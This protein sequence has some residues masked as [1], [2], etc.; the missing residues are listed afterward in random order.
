ML[1]RG[2]LFQARSQ[3]DPALPFRKVKER[4][5]KADVL[6][7]NL[8]SM[9]SDKGSDQGSQYSF[10]APPKMMEGLVLSEFD[11]LS[12][13][14]NHSFDWGVEA[15][16][17]TKK[18]LQEE[19]IIPVGGG[20]DAY[21]PRIISKNNYRFAFIAHT[22]LG[23]PGWR[24]TENTAGVAWYDE[25]ELQKSIE[26]VKGEVDA[27]IFSIHY[28]IE[29]QTEPSQNQIDISKNAIDMGV[30][31]VI[32]HHP[33]VI[34]PVEKYNDGIIAY[35]LGN[36]IFDQD[37]SEETMEGLLLEVNFKNGEIASYQ[38]EVIPIN[39]NFQ[40]YLD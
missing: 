30:D 1:D 11:V 14:N 2:V 38:K 8:E 37:F 24:P 34:Q 21:E 17:D 35:S 16:V 31:L 39:E 15:L 36:F 23:A 7:G 5:K 26:K 12:I 13:A 33:H 22:G 32:G 9:I 40:P 3:N 25:E 20:I 29:Y 10:R 4:L 27:I 6:F 19:G 28:G 18:R